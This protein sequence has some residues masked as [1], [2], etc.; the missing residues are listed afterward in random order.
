MKV[1][2]IILVALDV[3]LATFLIII[4]ANQYSRI[5]TTA[6]EQQSSLASIQKEYDNSD[7]VLLDGET[8]SAAKAISVARKY[9][10][11]LDLTKNDVPIDTGQSISRDL[12][13][14]N[15]KWVISV[16]RNVNGVTYALD[17]K[18]TSVTNKDPKNLADA[19]ATVAA[20]IGSNANESWT[21]IMNRIND[22]KKSDDY[23]SK[24]GDL[25][26]S[27]KDA[28]W[29]Q[30]YSGIEKALNNYEGS[31]VHACE[32][33]TI[34]ANST[35][36]WE[37]DNPTFCYLKGYNSYGLIVFNGSEVKVLGDFDQQLVQVNT[38]AKSITTEN[39]NWVLECTL[40]RM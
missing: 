22:I 2:H 21:D 10:G 13:A 24:L 18:D 14:D 35:A 27:S 36:K 39:Y 23:R 6:S 9:K 20:A 12:F 19:K 31:T 32:Q 40:I 11:V 15:T 37:M 16:K 17:F 26:G 3:I 8:V 1:T 5:S 30:V 38:S 33:F 25:V 29:D 7:A 34:P 4:C 28:N